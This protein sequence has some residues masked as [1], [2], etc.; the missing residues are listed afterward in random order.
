MIKRISLMTFLA[1]IL[2]IGATTVS[3]Q[4]KDLGS[5]EVKQG[6]EEDT[7]RLN[8]F[9]GQFRKIK[10]TVAHNKVKF[11][12]LEVEYKNG[13][14]ERVDIKKLINAGGSTRVIDLRG[15]DR[16]LNRV[17]VWYEAVKSKNDDRPRVTLW[18]FK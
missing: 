1:L 8:S 3:A 13:E 10:L 6:V 7:W 18:G 16:Y 5:R 14:T 12:R 4:W 11:L 17:N 9:H 2:S 15:N